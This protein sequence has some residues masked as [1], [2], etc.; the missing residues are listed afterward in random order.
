MFAKARPRPERLRYQP[1]FISAK[2]EAVL[3]G[4][5]AGRLDSNHHHRAESHGHVD[6][7][8]AMQSISGVDASWWTPVLRRPLNDQS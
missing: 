2:K 8:E 5:V 4:A 1:D 7:R 3:I 6:E